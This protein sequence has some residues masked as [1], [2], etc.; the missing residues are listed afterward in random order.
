[1]NAS[2]SVARFLPGQTVPTER[3][4]RRW[5]GHAGM[6]NQC[7]AGAR[8]WSWRDHRIRPDPAQRITTLLRPFIPKKLRACGS[9]G[10]GMDPMPIV[11][12]LGPELCQGGSITVVRLLGAF[13][14]ATMRE[15]MPMSATWAFGRSQPGLLTGDSGRRA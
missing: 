4:K 8:S 15:L 6:K 1:M 9:E 7:H 2:R 3:S 10:A 5:R 14:E 12:A 13:P 11:R